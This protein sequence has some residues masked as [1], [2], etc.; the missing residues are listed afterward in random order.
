MIKK[1]IFCLLFTCTALNVFGMDTPNDG[2]SL[3][4][5]Y[6]YFWQST[7]ENATSENGWWCQFNYLLNH[8]NKQGNIDMVNRL[9][10]AK[11]FIN[12]EYWCLH[13]YFESST[14]DD[15]LERFGSKG[16]FNMYI[17][18]TF[19]KAFSRD[20]QKLYS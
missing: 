12:N 14:I 13:K 2:C 16:C 8:F 3:V 15:C 20:K 17:A 9:L 1:I 10:S 6:E 7:I 5:E 4:T 11:K 18:T 19:W